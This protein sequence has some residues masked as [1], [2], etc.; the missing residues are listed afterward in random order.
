MT[1]FFRGS[2]QQHQSGRRLNKNQLVVVRRN[3][4]ERFIMN[5]LAHMT[6][7]VA[8]GKVS[9]RDF[10]QFALASGVTLAA[11]QALFTSA[12]RAEPKAARDV[13][14]AAFV[15]HYVRTRD[16]EV[17]E[18]QKSVSDWEVRRYFETV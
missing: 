9:R 2:N 13:L 14:G 6:S 7:L 10:I 16:W 18:Y 4:G 15:D 5:D 1:A 8:K 3:S 12:A 17:R 11:A